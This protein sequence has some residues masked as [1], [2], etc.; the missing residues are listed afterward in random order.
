MTEDPFG[1]TRNWWRRADDAQVVINGRTIAIEHEII[2]SKT[3]V[4]TDTTAFRPLTLVA[5]EP[6]Y[7]PD[8]N[9]FTETVAEMLARVEGDMDAE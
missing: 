8:Y 7:E 5:C 1:P 4:Y 9:E 2:V 3:D 6:G